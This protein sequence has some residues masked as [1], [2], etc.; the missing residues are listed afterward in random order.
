MKIVEMLHK[1]ETYNFCLIKAATLAKYLLFR[2]PN[3]ATLRQIV[4]TLKARILQLQN[5]PD[6]E[7][8][9][10]S[11]TDSDESTDIDEGYHEDNR[12][13]V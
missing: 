1:S 2:M 4:D 10:D 8:D 9:S 11:E 13:I 12:R 6:S 5:S 7:S 3:D